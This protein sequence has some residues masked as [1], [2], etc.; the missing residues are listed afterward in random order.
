[1]SDSSSP[2]VDFDAVASKPGLPAM[3]TFHGEGTD[4]LPD[5]VFVASQYPRAPASEEGSVMRGTLRAAKFEFGRRHGR[6]L[7]RRGVDRFYVTQWRKNTKSA[8]SPAWGSYSTTCIQ[9]LRPRPKKRSGK[10]AGKGAG[11]SK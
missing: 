10:G 6:A 4:M 8:Y 7:L 11:K 1:M 3:I 5:K 2:A 9:I